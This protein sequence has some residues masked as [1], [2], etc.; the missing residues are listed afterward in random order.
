MVNNK[1]LVSIGVPT[2]NRALTLGRAVES[3]LAQDYPNIELIISDNS[4]TDGTP[5]LCAEFCRRDRRIR[6]IRQEVNRGG[7][8]NFRA[9]LEEARGEFFLWLADDDWLA[10]DYVS[11]C[12]QIMIEQPEYALVGGQPLHCG[13]GETVLFDGD[14]INLSQ[15][16][17][18]ERVLEYLRQLHYDG[19]Y[20]TV[21]RRAQLLREPML[22]TI[23][24]DW[25][26]IS[27]IVFTGKLR[28]LDDTHLYRSDDGLSSTLESTVRVTGLP[29][30]FA[31][32][33][34][35]FYLKIAVSFFYYILITSP[36][37]KSLGVIER[38]SL[39]YAAFRVIQKRY[40][41]FQLSSVSQLPRRILDRV[42]SRLIVRT[43]LKRA[44]RTGRRKL[45]AL[46][47]RSA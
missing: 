16:S 22:N 12:M 43:R 42:R 23:A 9:V 5:A 1:P 31:R 39:A 40:I 25:L 41:R 36:S 19:A 32:H 21:M 27:S 10:T 34:N 46:G 15:D 37:Y 38:L 33:V 3:A 14:C 35:L 13:S 11:S 47:K 29:L 4:S 8:A 17:G 30:V 20:Y 26:L 18:R 45:D 24:G 28:M 6:Y 44:V 2:Y 7:T